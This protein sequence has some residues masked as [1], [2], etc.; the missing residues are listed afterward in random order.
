[1]KLSNIPD[2][3]QNKLRLTI[4]VSLLTGSK[5]FKEIK[6]IT[7][8]T[9]GNLSIQ[10]KKLENEKYINI[11]KEFINNKPCTVYTITPFGK[12]QLMD[13]VALLEKYTSN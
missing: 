3:L 7:K 13:Y 9:D 10:F 6:E 2:I 4:I 1:M 8:A 12:K 11:K 5:S